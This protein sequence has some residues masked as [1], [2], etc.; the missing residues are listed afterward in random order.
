MFGTLVNYWYLTG[1]NTY[2]NITSQALIYQATS[3]GDFLP[4]NQSLDEGND[5]Q[6]FWA[7]SAMMAAERNFPN[8]P[9]GS[10]SWLEM[11][12][13]VFNE[14]VS[15]WDNQ[16]C[17]G[18]LR[19]QIYEWNQGYNYRNSIA[20]GCFFDIAARLARYTGNQTYIEWAEKSWN[21]TASIGLIDP[22][23]YAIYD[24]SDDTS[25]CTSID[26]VQWTY[27]SGIFLHGAAVMYSIVSSSS[28]DDLIS[29]TKE[30]VLTDVKTNRSSL[31]EERVNGLL[32]GSGIFFSA[33]TSSENVMYEY[34]CE[35]INDCTTD[36]FSFKA[37]LSR[38]MYEAVQLAPFTNT[39]I[40]TKLK[41]TAETAAA[42]CV[43]GSTGTYCG[44][45]WT[46]GVYDG[47]TGIG[48]QMS[49]LEAV[50]GLL[51]PAGNVSMPLTNTTG[52]TSH[53]NSGAGDTTTSS[54]PM[55][56]TSTITMSDRVGAGFVTAALLLS[57]LGSLYFMLT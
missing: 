55:L 9:S 43:G 45:K 46:T 52:G 57:I 50:Q 6:S 40:M 16:T 25:N 38:W 14:Q 32:N 5:D 3:I 15:R 28:F 4:A 54:D 41:A 31:W 44:M 19:W 29:R 53:G 49:V 11:V 42:L 20:N 27:N 12:Q 33:N 22:R 24:G 1:D 48:Q 30:R 39:T 10:P 37:Y 35:L 47:T 23:T 51:T 17:G 2:N 21:W 8:P 13:A 18:G 26:H 36:Q 34:A 56:P 7:I